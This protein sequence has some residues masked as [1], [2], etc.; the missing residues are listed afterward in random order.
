M[1]LP[2]VRDAKRVFEGRYYFKLCLNEEATLRSRGQ[3]VDKFDFPESFIPQS[4]RQE[5][6][7]RKEV[8]PRRGIGARPGR[9][10]KA[11]SS[12]DCRSTV[13]R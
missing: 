13:D 2:V 9:R 11:P 4:V 12:S 5:L 10:R 7:C 1:R 8:R 6:D 3:V